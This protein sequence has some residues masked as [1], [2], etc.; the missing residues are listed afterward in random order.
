MDPIETHAPV[1]EVDAVSKRF[2]GVVALDEVSMA[3]RPGEV[4][5]L[6]GENGAGKSTLIKV[7]T[8]VH[9]PDEGQVRYL[10]QPVTFTRPR[11]AQ[12]AGISTIYQEVNLVPL[13]SVARNLFLGREPTNRLGLIDTARM[14]REASELLAGYGISRG[15]PPAA[16]RARPGRPA[17]G[18][19]RPG[20][21]DLRP[22]RHHGRADL[23]A[24]AARGRAAV[25]GGRPAAGPAGGRA[26]RHPQ[27]R[28]GVQGLPAGDRPARRPARPQRRRRRHHPAPAGGRHARPRR[29]RGAGPRRHQLRRGAPAARRPAGAG[30]APS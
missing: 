11:D 30:G 16:A 7:M 10:G 24:G 18:R 2:A 12:A 3:L 25:R 8:G 5:A 1:L 26:L 20:G 28:R 23:V 14:H 15:R 13:L 19:D 27:A 6:V 29:R 17:D 22:G 4:H 21:V 9:Q